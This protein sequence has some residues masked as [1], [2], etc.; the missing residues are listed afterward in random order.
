MSKPTAGEI[1]P[2]FNVLTDEEKPFGKADL[3]GR[4][5][6]LYFYPK[7]GTSGC[8]LEARNLQEGSAALAAAGLRVIGVSPDSTASHRRFRTRN[9]LDFTL[10]SDPDHTMCEAFGVWGEKQMYGRKYYGVIRTTFIIDE[11]GR[12]EHVFD[13]VDT[14]NHYRQILEICAQ[15]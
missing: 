5:T 9:G 11:T 1:I 3:A 7:D 8:T 4:R 10:L 12:I 2:D 15:K 13:K 6:V 14:R